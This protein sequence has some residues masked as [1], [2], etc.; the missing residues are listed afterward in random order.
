MVDAATHSA[1]LV[2][3]AGVGADLALIVAQNPG[4]ANAGPADLTVS[5]YLARFLRWSL[6]NQ[7]AA[8]VLLLV[9]AVSLVYGFAML[10]GS[11]AE[12]N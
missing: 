4:E 2:E 5:L 3:L 10:V 7:A 12:V 11:L 9:L 1:Q 8:T 6:L